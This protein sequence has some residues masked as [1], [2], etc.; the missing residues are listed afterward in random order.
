MIKGRL[1]GKREDWKIG[2][3]EDW[4]IRGKIGRGVKYSCLYRLYLLYFYLIHIL[5]IEWIVPRK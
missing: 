3:L 2:R 4:K 1:E 5:I